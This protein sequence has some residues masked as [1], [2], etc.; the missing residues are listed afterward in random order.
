MTLFVF[1]EALLGFRIPFEEEFGVPS[2]DGFLKK[3]VRVRCLVSDPPLEAN[4][5]SDGG[6]R[7]G[8]ES[9]LAMV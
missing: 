8:V 5:L 9:V 7:A 4:F 2:D 6:A 3:D 1:P